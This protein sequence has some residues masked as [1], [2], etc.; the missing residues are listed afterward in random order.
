MARNPPNKPSKHRQN[1]K[2][3]NSSGN[4]PKQRSGRVN[5]SSQRLSDLAPQTSA[6]LDIPVPS[7]Q[8]RET[9]LS[10]SPNLFPANSTPTSSG[11]LQIPPIPRP[12]QNENR[13]RYL[14]PLNL[15][16][17]LQTGSLIDGEHP[18]NNIDNNFMATIEA[19]FERQNIFNERLDQRLTDHLSNERGNT[20]RKKLLPKELSVS[21]VHVPF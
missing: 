11:C 1:A 5:T 16:P 20:S 6:P 18:T 8:Q 19:F 14:E 13:R 10:S 4:I 12:P 17:S 3:P 21:R 2:T 7:D 15:G 9:T